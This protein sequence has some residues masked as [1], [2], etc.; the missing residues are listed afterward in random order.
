MTSR[1]NAFSTRNLEVFAPEIDRALAALAA[2]DVIARIHRLDGAVWTG[3]PGEIAARL[4]W[5]RAP[6]AMAEEAPRLMGWAD[7][8][9][10]EGFRS[11]LLLGMGGSSL[12][13]EV[14]GTVFS[15]RRAPDRSS[16]FSTARR[17]TRSSAPPRDTI[18]RRLSTS[19]PRNREPPPKPTPS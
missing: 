8:P 12:A 17:P 7:G 4:G 19:S 2:D 5:L 3:A 6:E 15:V 13:P 11:I 1:S 9:R 16:R 18:P 10:G 14:F